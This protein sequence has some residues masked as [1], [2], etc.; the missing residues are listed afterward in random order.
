MPRSAE[1]GNLHGGGRARAVGA[2]LLLL[3]DGGEGQEIPIGVVRA[4]GVVVI[5]DAKLHRPQGAPM[6]AKGGLENRGD[7][8]RRMAEGA[9]PKSGQE[10]SVAAG[11]FDALHD[12]VDLLLHG[13][14][15]T[16]VAT[17]PA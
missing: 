14:L 9:A 5:E 16:W 6:P 4:A 2:G 8:F 3:Q 10:G 11:P 17:P 7:L 13:L 15:V 1:G 12:E